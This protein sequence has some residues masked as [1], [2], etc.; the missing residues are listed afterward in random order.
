MANRLTHLVRVLL[1]DMAKVLFAVDSLYICGGNGFTTD[2]YN[3][4]KH[5]LLVAK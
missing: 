2:T 5:A 3:I 1:E 4:C